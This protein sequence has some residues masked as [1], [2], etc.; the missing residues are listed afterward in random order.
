MLATSPPFVS[1][2][3][4]KCGIFEVSQPCGPPRPVTRLA[5]YLH[6]TAHNSRWISAA[7]MFFFFLS[8]EITTRRLRLAGL[9]VEGHIITH[10]VETRTNTR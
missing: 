2:L 9:S 7:L 4:R 8:E 10:S 6:Y 5:L 1:K 3:S